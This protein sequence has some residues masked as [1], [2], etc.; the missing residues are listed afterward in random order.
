[1]NDTLTEKTV[2][3]MSDFPRIHKEL[4]VLIDSKTPDYELGFVDEDCP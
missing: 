3:D 2:K 1:M 4:E